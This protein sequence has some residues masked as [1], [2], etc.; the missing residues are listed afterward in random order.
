MSQNK[1]TIIEHLIITLLCF[2]Y[3]IMFTLLFKRDLFDYDNQRLFY[4][5]FLVGYPL[6]YLVI[7]TERCLY[8]SNKK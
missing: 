8:M 7:N 5:L 1:I 2:S 4:I 6:I 3:P